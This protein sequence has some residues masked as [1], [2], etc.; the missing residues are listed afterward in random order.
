[1]R[2]FAWRSFTDLMSELSDWPS[3]VLKTFAGGAPAGEDG[4]DQQCPGH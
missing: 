1:M 3:I 2:Y 4:Q